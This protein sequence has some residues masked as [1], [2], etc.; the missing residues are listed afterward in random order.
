MGQHKHNPNCQLAKE[1]IL[2]PKPKPMGKIE[3]DRWLYAK[4][5]EILYAPLMKAYA[6]MDGERKEK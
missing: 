4:C 5:Q 6:K 1:G 3:M 2:K